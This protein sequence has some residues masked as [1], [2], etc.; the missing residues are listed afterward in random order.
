MISL[1]SGDSDKLAV[2]CAC[3]LFRESGQS[4]TK[5]NPQDRTPTLSFGVFTAFGTEVSE[6]NA[7][8]L[9]ACPLWSTCQSNSWASP[10][11]Q[12]W[13]TLHKVSNDKQMVITHEQQQNWSFSNYV[14]SKN[15]VAKP[16]IS[17]AACIVVSSNRRSSLIT[18]GKVDRSW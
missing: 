14:V 2:S 11:I 4:G 18:S 8:P 5:M 9:S 15:N 6:L 13:V 17:W 12:L 3:N 10:V 16:H 1:V 7:E